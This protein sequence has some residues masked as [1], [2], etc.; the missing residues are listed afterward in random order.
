M[1]GKKTG[2]RGPGSLNKTTSTVKQVLLSVFQELQEDPKNNLKS[3]AQTQPTEFY[4][5]ASKLI[6]TEI[7][8]KLSKI[9][10]EI[11][12]NNTTSPNDT[13]F[14]SAEGGE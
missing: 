13:S 14:A 12:R 4:K 11:V 3:W 8:A 6:P 1:K 10:L 2:G 9:T 7:N 5:I